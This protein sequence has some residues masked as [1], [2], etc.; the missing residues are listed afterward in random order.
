ML[1]IKSAMNRNSKTKL[2]NPLEIRGVKNLISVFD[3]FTHFFKITVAPIPMI[4]LAVVIYLTLNISSWPI[5]LQT[6]FTIV[7]TLLSG[8]IGA[9]WYDRYK[10]SNETGSIIKKSYSSIRNLKLIKFK[11]MEILM[12]LKTLRSTENIRDMDEL[13]SHIRN[14]DKDIVNSISDWEDVNPGSTDLIKAYEEIEL[15]KRQILQLEKDKGDI[16]INKEKET[17]EVKIKLEKQVDIKNQEIQKLREQVRSIESSS[18]SLGTV[19]PGS[20]FLDQGSVTFP[21]QNEAHRICKECGREYSQ[22]M[23][24]VDNGKCS[25]CNSGNFLHVSPFKNTI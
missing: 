8:L 25:I 13:E 12:R 15:T 10:K 11:I 18:I 23:T 4:C 2:K 5:L 9:I 22:S 14:I 16:T 24:S 20:Y 6:A 17:V 21:Y 19:N 7:I 1:I 3:E